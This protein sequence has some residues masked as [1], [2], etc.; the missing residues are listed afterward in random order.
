MQWA[1]RKHKKGAVERWEGW[2]E[3]S[4]ALEGS[5]Y[6]NKDDIKWWKGSQV[7]K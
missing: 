3:N 6:W 2:E 5:G 4:W 7:K 1:K